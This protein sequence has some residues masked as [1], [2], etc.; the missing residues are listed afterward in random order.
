MVDFTKRANKAGAGS[1][2]A[3]ETVLAA[4]NM[5]PTPFR[6]G[7]SAMV[8]GAIVG[9]VVGAVIG[10]AV[11]KR[12]EQKAADE[13]A[14]ALVPAVAG[15][16]PARPLPGNGFLLGVTESRILVWS[17]GGLGKPGDLLFEVPLSRVDAVAWMEADPKWMRGAPRSTLFWIGVGG[18]TVL[19]T[20][21][22]S[23]G[24]A[25]K[26]VRAVVEAL[27]RALPGRVREFT[28]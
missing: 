12:R 2:A 23:A 4:T 15:R 22:I 25:G 26:Y 27:D 18:D 3:G 7:G 20:A 24:P 10:S 11:D 13:D 6:V 8:S 1:L 21:A 28:P 16:P 17:I 19:S 5:T 9:G 14:T